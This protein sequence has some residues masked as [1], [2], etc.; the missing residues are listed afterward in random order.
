MSPATRP[1]L[2]R[3]RGRDRDEHSG[4]SGEAQGH[5]GAELR[6]EASARTQQPARRP[7]RL[8]DPAH[9][10]P[11]T[12]PRPERARTDSLTDAFLRSLPRGCE[13]LVLTIVG[14]AWL[15]FLPTTG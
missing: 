7:G 2:R 5:R 13:R 14:F 11:R 1:R 3:L 8:E 10:R 4:G 15:P 12:A 9:D 6:A